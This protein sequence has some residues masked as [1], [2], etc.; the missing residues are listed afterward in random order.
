MRARLFV[1]LL[2]AA[3]SPAEAPRSVMPDAETRAEVAEALGRYMVAARAV[4]ADAIAAFFTPTGVLFEPGIFPI[5][6]ADSIRAF[7]GSFPGVVVDSAVSMPE[8]IEVFGDTALLWGSY[9]EKLSF[10]GQPVSEQH[11]RF[12]M[13]WVRQPDGRWLIQRYYRVPLPAAPASGP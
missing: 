8:T 7:M 12:V 3:C 13:E 10:P 1:T 6:G 9:F 5:L 2:L 11:G 4:D